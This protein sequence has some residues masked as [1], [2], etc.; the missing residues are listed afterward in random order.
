MKSTVAEITNEKVVFF[1]TIPNLM[2]IT[3][4]PLFLTG[5]GYLDRLHDTYAENLVAKVNAA[6][7]TV[8]LVKGL[9]IVEDLTR[10]KSKKRVSTLIRKSYH[11][12]AEFLNKVKAG[13]GYVEGET[14]G[15]DPVEYL[16]L[17]EKTIDGE[18]KVILD[19]FD[20]KSLD[21]VDVDVLKGII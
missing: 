10:C 5:D 17:V 3:D 16:A 12:K 15:K 19:A 8:N 11:R 4:I 6:G 7:S 9:P 21:K 20:I 1:T 13:V 18:Y 14:K 2:D